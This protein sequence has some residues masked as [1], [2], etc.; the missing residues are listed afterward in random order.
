MASNAITSTI[1][2][3]CGSSDLMAAVASTRMVFATGPQS[4]IKGSSLAE[5]AQRW[6]V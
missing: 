3:I 1:A 5:I 6:L 2:Q 4:R